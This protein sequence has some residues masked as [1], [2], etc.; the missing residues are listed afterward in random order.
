MQCDC[1]ASNGRDTAFK[2]LLGDHL[3]IH[4]DFVQT[5]VALHR[6]VVCMWVCLKIYCLTATFVT[7]NAKLHLAHVE[8]SPSPLETPVSQVCLGK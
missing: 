3:D 6:A 5:V 7:V 1:I 2:Q 8:H 4:P